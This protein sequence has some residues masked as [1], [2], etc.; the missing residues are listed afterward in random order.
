M[1]IQNKANKEMDV[2]MMAFC[3]W[4]QVLPASRREEVPA[5]KMVS[6]RICALLFPS[7]RYRARA[8]RSLVL[9]LIHRREAKLATDHDDSLPA[10]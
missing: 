5:T 1:D 8:A 7:T 2:A 9:F 6:L 3:G 10:A 4:H